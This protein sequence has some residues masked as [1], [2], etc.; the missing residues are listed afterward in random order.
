MENLAAHGFLDV[1]LEENY[2]NICDVIP[3]CRDIVRVGE[4]QQIQGQEWRFLER[5]LGD[6]TYVGWWLSALYSEGTY[7]KIYKA[8]RMVVKKRSDGLFDVVE[9]PTEVIVKKTE[10]PSKGSAKVL[11]E[12]DI[13]A[14]TS[15]ALLHV[16]AWKT[17]Q[18]TAAP[19]AIPRPYEV[20]GE[21]SDTLG[22]W[23][24]M[25]LCMSYVR[26]RTLHAFLERYWR[27]GY[28]YENGRLF[29]E[30][31]AQTAYILHH[32]QTAMR[33]NHRDVK[34]NNI[35]ISRRSPV[36][37]ELNGARLETQYELTLI[38]FGFACVGCP[39]PKK[40]MT[41]FQAGSWFPM[42]EICCKTGRDIAQ[43]LFC[44]YCYFPFER[45]LP[46]RLCVE[47]R[48]WVRVICSSGVVDILHGFDEDGG[49]RP[50]TSIGPPQ[51]HTGIYE[52]LRRKDVD[53]IFCAPEKVFLECC[54]YLSAHP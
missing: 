23:P 18:R 2:E 6:D 8:H 50:P 11:P 32:L 29:M 52:F 45:F 39:P 40:P 30:L 54:R 10:P 15:E 49:P 22:G 17:I 28:I 46:T 38:D 35:L 21:Y 43:L 1:R 53:P 12:E 20:F 42:G 47:L 24:S 27:R 25:S 31:L 16:L 3:H 33:L 7:G 19:W 44:I 51:F 26:G 4:P 37:L 48:S 34:V 41:V 14:H 36:T 9:M 13:H 5:S